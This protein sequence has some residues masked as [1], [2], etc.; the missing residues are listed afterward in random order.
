MLYLTLLHYL[1]LNFSLFLIVQLTMDD[2]SLLLLLLLLLLSLYITSWLVS[3]Y[4][5]YS[6]VVKNRLN[7]LKRTSEFNNPSRRVSN[8]N[9]SNDP[10]MK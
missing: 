2:I 5:L 8:K 9:H 7:Q 3:A 1:L 6:Q 4:D 10:T